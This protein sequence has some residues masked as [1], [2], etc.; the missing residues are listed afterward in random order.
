[1]NR[2][3]VA[4]VLVVLAV[5]MSAAVVPGGTALLAQTANPSRVLPDSVQRGET[6]NVT[7]TFTSPAN[8]FNSIYLFDVAPDGWNVTVD[9]TWC[10]PNADEVSATGN[11][12]EIGW[13][14]GSYAN[15]TA[16]TAVYQV[17]VP[18][19]AQLGTHSFAGMLRY[20]LGSQGPYG[21]SI[22][23]DSQVEAIL[24]VISFSPTNFS[25][26]AIEGKGAPPA[27]TLN[28]WNSGGETVNW[29]IYDDADWL[30]ETPSNGTLAVGEHDYVGVSVATAG[31]A[32]GMH[33][34]NISLHAVNA[35][36]SIPVSLEI[37][38]AIVINVTRYIN[39]T[40]R[41]PNELYPGDTFAVVVKW[42]A[43]LNN[44]S[45]IGLTD[46]AP[47]GFEVAANKTWCSPTANETKATGNE[48]EIIWYG[49]YAKG[50]NF[51]AKYNVT[52]PST[53]A[54][55]SHFFPY[56]DCSQGW[57]EYYFGEQWVY[58]SCTMGD[59][60]IVV[61]VPGDIVGETRDVNA[62][63]LSG[64]TVTLY[65]DSSGIGS[66]TST[67]NYSITVNMTGEYYW[68]ANKTRYYEINTTNGLELPGCNFTIAL[69][70]PELLAAGYTF[71]FEG[72]YGLIPGNCDMSYALRS[73]NLWLSPPV[74]HPEW[75]I[76]EW[77]AMD[78]CS[79]WLYPS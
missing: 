10:T 42:T 35:T 4:G 28:I 49:P 75:G 47:P 5:L 26:S 64:V 44:F 71:D 56:N 31:L 8:G 77:K 73:V 58:T 41:L 68:V 21:E 40:L 29:T 2:M 60:E 70:T 14:G 66:D 39:G 32:L 24:P 13:W 48:V 55:G 65:K 79:A 45:A 3:R 6:F 57:L 46:L 36:W 54:A 34:A 74:G 7:V 61:T 53:A 63:E 15:G 1:M 12:S 30:E 72:D 51:T 52:V 20:Y 19:D 17:T 59:N 9:K 25:F 69:T 33:S 16:F 27:Q 23:G 11:K 62:N 22:A 67:P 50:T 43:P 76:S 78:V 18:H 38:E 37:K